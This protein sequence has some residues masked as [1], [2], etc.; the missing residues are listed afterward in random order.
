MPAVKL[1]S[2]FP[3]EPAGQVTLAN[4]RTAPFN[5]WAFQHVREIV[6]SADIPQDPARVRELTAKPQDLARLKV[7]P[8][9]LGKALEATSTDGIVVLHRG[10]IVF[11]RYANGMTERTPHILMS[12]SKSMLGLLAGILIGKRALKRDALVTSIIPEVKGTAY[13]GAT[14][15]QALDMRVGIL[16]DEDYLATSGPIVEYRKA[17]NWNPLAPGDKPSDLRSF[18]KHLKKKDGPHGGRFHYVSPN[19]D[20]LGWIIERAGG[21]RYADLMSKLLWQPAGAAEPAYITVDRLGAPRCAGGMNTTTRDL[22]RVGQMLVEGGACGRA[23]VVPEAWIDGILNKGD[24]EAWKAGA[25]LPYYGDAPMHYRA[26]WYVEREKHPRLFGMGI[27][28][29]N[30]FVDPKNQVVIAKFSSQAPPLDPGLIGKTTE[31]VTAI[32]HALT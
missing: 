11:E 10:A 2:G 22:A 18:Y 24:T 32:R 9:T 7:G 14:I 16:F 25:F 3:P 6:P 19:T 31:L 12:V 21:A 28:G 30:L 13:D 4:W 1:M 20:L 29:Q 15:D 8:T 27:H 5:Q 17:T 26:K 23:Q